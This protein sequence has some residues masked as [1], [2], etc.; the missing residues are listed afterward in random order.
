MQ[1]IH[2]IIYKINVNKNFQRTI[3]WS[4]N[5]QSF[6]EYTDASY[7]CNVNCLKNTSKTRMMKLENVHNYILYEKHVNY[8]IHIDENTMRK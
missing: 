8:V 3:H 6:N 2:E 5:K 4:V 7:L 1:L